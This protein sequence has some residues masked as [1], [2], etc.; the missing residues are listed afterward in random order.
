MLSILYQFEYPWLC[1]LPVLLGF[2]VG[3]AV[4]R[5]RFKVALAL[6]MLIVPPLAWE[7]LGWTF[8]QS[9]CSGG[10]CTGAMI[11][12]VLLALP[13]SCIFLVGMGLASATILQGVIRWARA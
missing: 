4:G 12:L 7:V 3:L 1:L 13:L 5:F 11:I 10:D 6:A 8:G 2:A 9:G